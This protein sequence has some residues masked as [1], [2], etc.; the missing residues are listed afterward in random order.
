TQYPQNS[1]LRKAVLSTPRGSAGEMLERL[2]REGFFESASSGKEE[3]LAAVSRIVGARSL[4]PELSR[5][6][7]LMDKPEMAAAHWQEAGLRGLKLGLEMAATRRLRSS[8]AEQF[9]LRRIRSGSDQMQTLARDLAVHFEMASLIEDAAREATD[10]AL[11]I[12]RRVAATRILAGAPFG[13]A[14]VILEQLLSAEED[15]QVR[16][17]AIKTMASVE[18]R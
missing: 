13:R 2:L 6:F 10:G 8:V 5:W 12:P 9:I 14:G 15:P 4:S 1:R 17:A 18:S 3:L 16:Q 7:G 11:S